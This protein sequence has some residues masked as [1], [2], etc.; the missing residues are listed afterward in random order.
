MVNKANVNES[1]RCLY[2]LSKF[3]GESPN[4]MFQERTGPVPGRNPA[5][6][7]IEAR[8]Y[9]RCASDVLPSFLIDGGCVKQQKKP[10]THNGMHLI[11]VIDERRA[12]YTGRE[13]FQ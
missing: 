9:T 5:L 11:I 10:L 1:V 12:V 2:C 7:Q 3:R 13:K 6:H 8:R 4:K